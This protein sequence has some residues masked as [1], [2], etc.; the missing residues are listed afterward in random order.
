MDADGA[1]AELIA[2]LG[3]VHELLARPD[4]DFTWSSWHDTADALA[5][6]DGLIAELRGG[7]V[8]AYGVACVFMA[9]GPLEEVSASSG[10]GDAFVELASRTE[11]ALA[12]LT[13]EAVFRCGIC[14]AQAGSVRLQGTSARAEIR[15]ESFIGVIL[16]TV[17]PA[18]YNPLRAALAEDDARRLFEIDVELT[19]FYCPSCD[20]AYCGTHWERWDVWDD[21]HPDWHDAIRGRCP[22]GHE[23][24][25]ED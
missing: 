2:V 6:V 18:L 10:W 17:E 20:T 9:T 1:R 7:S 11:A 23:R 5:E 4:S 15:R 8:P 25:L 3:T 19:P 21:D 16:R 14:D 13:S 12:V 22:R 24:M